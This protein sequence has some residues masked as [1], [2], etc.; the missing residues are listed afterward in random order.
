M[1]FLLLFL[2]SATAFKKYN[3]IIATSF[4]Y[5]AE[6]T[7]FFFVYGS[8][9]GKLFSHLNKWTL[10]IIIFFM[11]FFTVLLAGFEAKIRGIVI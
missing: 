6:F 8:E 1:L 10:I 11:L 4:C 2:I 5:V 7:L 9:R 3:L